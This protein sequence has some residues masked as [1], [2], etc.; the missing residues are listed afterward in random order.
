ML[1]G[2]QS[3]IP[4]PHPTEPLTYGS[5]LRVP[6]LTDLQ[7]PVQSPEAHDELLFIIVQQVQ[8][9][10]FKQ[11]MHE[12]RTIIGLLNADSIWEAVRLMG[13]VNR[14]MEAIGREV[15]LLETMPPTEFA[16]FRYVLDTASGFESQQFRELELASGLEDRAFLKLIER[17]MDVNAM[18]ARW[19][20]SLHEAFL[21]VLRTVNTDDETE[22]LVRVYSDHALH[23]EMFAL[24]EAL[25]EYELLFAQWRFSHIKLVARTIGDHA[26]GTAGSSGAG[27]LGRT[28]GYRFFPELWEARNRLTER[29]SAHTK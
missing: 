26:T 29:A 11:I 28:L 27:Y 19:P 23:P 14:I 22:A 1:K 2:E 3:E 7:A 24:A 20:Q 9:L 21:G 25:T 18:R 17:H 10:W 13:R 4:I 6:Q 8:E 15:A 12:L 5:Y 16:R